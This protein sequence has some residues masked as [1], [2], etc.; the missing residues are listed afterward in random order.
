M[1]THVLLSLIDVLLHLH[2]NLINVG[3]REERGHVEPSKVGWGLLP[4]QGQLYVC[5]C[6]SVCVT[7]S[8]THVYILWDWNLK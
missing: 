2:P 3:V 7:Y 1:H 4:L 5:V 6:E 8:C